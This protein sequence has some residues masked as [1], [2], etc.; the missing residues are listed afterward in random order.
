MAGYRFR[1]VTY[2]A[3]LETALVTRN[4][5]PDAKI[6]FVDAVE[7]A[8]RIVERQKVPRRVEL[9]DNGVLLE[10]SDVVLDK[11]G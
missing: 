3:G 8:R 7:R 1:I 5:L 11:A 9:L 10:A 2:R 4:L 6:A